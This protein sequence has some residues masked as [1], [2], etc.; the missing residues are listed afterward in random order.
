[1]F[2][3]T[4]NPESLLFDHKFGKVNESAVVR[5][6]RNKPESCWIPGLLPHSCTTWLVGREV[7]LSFIAVPPCGIFMFSV[8]PELSQMRLTLQL[9]GHGSQTLEQMS[10]F[11]LDSSSAPP[12]PPLPGWLV[13]LH[14]GL[15]G[16]KAWNSNSYSTVSLSASITREAWERQRGVRMSGHEC[17]P[18]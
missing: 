13:C 9:K 2:T 3:S 18:P 1:M 12:P 15:N 4:V 17:R 10:A 8:F 7:G 11:D 14:R 6:V 16:D 5:Q